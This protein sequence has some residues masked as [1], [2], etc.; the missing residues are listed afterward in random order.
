MEV[1]LKGLHKALAVLELPMAPEADMK[2]GGAANTNPCHH[3]HLGSAWSRDCRLSTTMGYVR[4]PFNCPL[5]TYL[6][7]P[8][9]IQAHAE[10][11]STLRLES[12]LEAFFKQIL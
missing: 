10:H 2:I 4:S 12:L 7:L 1:S 11:L 9:K 3:F 6:A 8:P 5:G